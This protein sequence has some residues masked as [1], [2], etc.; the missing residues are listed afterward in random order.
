MGKFSFQNLSANSVGGGGGS[1]RVGQKPTF[2]IFLTLPLVSGDSKSFLCSGLTARSLWIVWGILENYYEAA[3][4][5][6]SAVASIGTH[7]YWLGKTFWYIALKICL[8]KHFDWFQNNISIEVWNESKLSSVQ[9]STVKYR[10]YLDIL[11]LRNKM[12]FC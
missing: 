9:Y 1:G 6:V 10:I 12:F 4:A 5:P 7:S 11:S 8:K 3:V 2:L